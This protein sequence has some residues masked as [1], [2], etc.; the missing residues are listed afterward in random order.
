MARS[1]HRPAPVGR[2]AAGAKRV[3]PSRCK[4][5]TVSKTRFPARHRQ[6]WCVFCRGTVGIPL[7]AYGVF[8]LA[9]RMLQFNGTL[10]RSTVRGK[11]W[12]EW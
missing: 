8:P 6:R 11:I 5:F 9:S 12:F 1:L 3:A 4:A 2:A 10:I 7:D